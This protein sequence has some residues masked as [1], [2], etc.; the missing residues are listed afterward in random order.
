MVSVNKRHKFVNL[1]FKAHRKTHTEYLQTHF[2]NCLK[3]KSDIF[4]RASMVFT[5]DRSNTTNVDEIPL[6]TIIF[7]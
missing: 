5:V 3:R 6:N 2:E 4:V 1:V 7:G